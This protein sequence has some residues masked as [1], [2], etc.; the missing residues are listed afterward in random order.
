[1]L[2][3]KISDAPGLIISG[4]LGKFLWVFNVKNRYHGACHSTTCFFFY[5]TSIEHQSCRV[6]KSV[7][8]YCIMLL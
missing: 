1:M 5:H 4:N 2:A 7:C 6:R 8:F 3:L